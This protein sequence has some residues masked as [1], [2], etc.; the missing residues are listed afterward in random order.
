VAWWPHGRAAPEE[1][2]MNTLWIVIIVGLGIAVL[3]LVAWIARPKGRGL[4][5]YLSL[6]EPRMSTK[7]DER[8]LRVSF[9]GKAATTIQAAYGALFK[10]YFSLKGAPKGPA[11]KAP[12]ARYQLPMD[13]GIDPEER[14]RDFEGNSWKGEVAI[15]LPESVAFPERKGRPDGMGAETAV[16][17]YGEVAEILHLGP[18]ATETPTIRKLEDFIKA[19]GYEVVGE[20]EEEYL[21]GPGM[22]FVKPKDYWTI[23]RYRVRKAG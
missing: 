4:S 6:K 8:V 1:V 3:A 12:K 21:K 19:R 18:Y 16:W 14:L 23:I 2:S 10:S 11:M 15:P 22:P 5:D 7:P 17:S 9:S 13:L 20:H